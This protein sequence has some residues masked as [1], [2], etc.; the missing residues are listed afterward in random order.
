MET[1]LFVSS[2]DSNA[3]GPSHDFTVRFQPPIEL[4][5]DAAYKIALQNAELWHAWRNVKKGVNDTFR[6]NNGV[7]WK[8][9]T[10]D[11]GAYNIVTLD[12]ELS[13]QLKANGDW[14]TA[15]KSAPIALVANYNTL[16]TLMRVDDKYSVDFTI[17]KSLRDLL[18]FD[19]KVI[20][21]PGVFTSDHRLN[22]TVTQSILL[23]CDLT[24]GSYLDGAKSSV[25]GKMIPNHPPGTLL[26]Y[27]PFRPYYLPVNRNDFISSVRLRV[28]NQNDEPLD[29]SDT[30]VN[31]TL[32]LI[33]STGKL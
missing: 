24:Y 14:D 29:L 16:R 5:T 11:A 9:I 23:H 25:I 10:I 8:T 12:E 28:T 32:H 15:K 21:G 2:Q 27:Q 6:Y 3:T 22:I 33:E 7:T 30:P 20:R 17:Q 1:V 31:Y 4:S 13:A 19:A 18:G 26:T